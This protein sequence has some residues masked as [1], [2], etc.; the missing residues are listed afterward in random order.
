MGGWTRSTRWLN[1]NGYGVSTVGAGDWAI[2]AVETWN[3]NHLHNHEGQR[4]EILDFSNLMDWQK[5]VDSTANV[6]TVSSSYRSFSFAG[7]QMGWNSDDAFEGLRGAHMFHLVSLSL[8]ISLTVCL[9]RAL[10]CVCV[11]LVF[12]VFCWVG[13]WFLS[14]GKFVLTHRLIPVVDRPCLALVRQCRK[15]KDGIQMTEDI[16]HSQL[17]TNPV[18]V[19]N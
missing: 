4:A 16:L 12:V 3:K 1:D 18:M 2:E 9:A 6:L 14:L 8:Q 11:L 13:C 15:K 19:F 5:V 10:A 17:H 7:R